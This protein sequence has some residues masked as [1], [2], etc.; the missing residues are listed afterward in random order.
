MS[1]VDS[2]L[3]LLRAKKFSSNVNKKKNEDFISKIRKFF[4]NDSSKRR[5][6][7]IFTDYGL[8]VTGLSQSNISNCDFYFDFVCIIAQFDII[9]GE[10]VTPI[11]RWTEEQMKELFSIPPEKWIDPAVDFKLPNSV[12]F[13]FIV[14]GLDID[15][16]FYFQLQR[17]PGYVRIPNKLDLQDFFMIKDQKID[18]LSYDLYYHYSSIY[19]ILKKYNFNFKKATEI[20]KVL[21]IVNPKNGSGSEGS[22]DTECLT[23][24]SNLDYLFRNIEDYDV[25]MKLREK[26]IPPIKDLLK[27]YRCYTDEEIVAYFQSKPGIKDQFADH[28]LALLLKGREG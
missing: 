25:M 24:T 6:T 18:F 22:E 3:S 15:D 1:S 14:L 26:E 21:G 19:A 16:S 27:E 13:T 28:E 7:S 20:Y 4:L 2:F 10:G 23:Y 12:F 9:F 17:C 5:L 8:K 11:I